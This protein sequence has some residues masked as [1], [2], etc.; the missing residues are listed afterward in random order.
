LC[1]FTDLSADIPMWRMHTPL[2]GP[3]GRYAGTSNR[4]TDL[5]GSGV[6]DALTVGK[7]KDNANSQL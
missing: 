4:D 7:E 6:L 2:V 5:Q 3:A 1:G